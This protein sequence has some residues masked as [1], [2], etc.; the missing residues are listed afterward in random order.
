QDA[1][2]VGRALGEPL[3]LE[4]RR[5]DPV[6]G[7]EDAVDVAHVDDVV[8]LAPGVLAEAA[9]GQAAEQR[10]LT[11]LEQGTEDLGAGAR[12]LA[13]AAAAGRLAVAAADAAP[14]PLLGPALGDA[15]VYLT[16]IH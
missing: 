8:V 11:A 2:A 1:H 10:R 3:G 7:G 9:L 4:R 12:V 13:L 6:A 16:E 15:L 14:D 5:V